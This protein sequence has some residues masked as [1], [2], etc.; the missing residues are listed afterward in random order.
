M[1]AARAAKSL[2]AADVGFTDASNR[3]YVNDHLNADTK[4]L[5]SRTI[6]LATEKSYSYVW[7][8][9][10]KYVM[11]RRACSSSPARI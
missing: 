7:I 4:T 1:A 9:Y 6:S 10:E 8:K 11:T 3:V 2:T 5:L